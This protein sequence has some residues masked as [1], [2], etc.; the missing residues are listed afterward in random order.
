MIEF[1]IDKH[2]SLPV[3]AQLQEQIKIALMLGRLRPGDTLPSI[4]DVE[5]ET[6]ISRNI[7]RQAYLSLEKNGILTLRHGKGVMVHSSLD[8]PHKNERLDR[9]EQLVQEVLM[10]ARELDVVPSAFA[11]YLRQRAIE[12]ETIEPP[13]IY[14]DVGKQIA[15]ERSARIS[16]FW[17]MT[18][19]PFSFEE[20]VEFLSQKKPQRLCVLTNY[21]RLDAVRQMLRGKRIQV[22][23]LGLTFTEEAVRDFSGLARNSNVLLVVEDSDYPVL[24]LIAKPYR[25]LLTDESVKFE[26]RPLSKI[27]NLDALAR[28]GRYA[29]IVI[30]NRLWEQMSEKVRNLPNVTRPQLQ[31]DLPSLEEARIKAGV[32][33]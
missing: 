4:R 5:K 30:S 15:F 20:F 6:A 8:Y 12:A 17:G 9:T 25:V 24:S 1:K 22:I 28:S 23:P 19:P 10:K 29:R 21:I 7:V 11:R 31:I 32:I 14:V 27:K 26:T 3:V 16:S 13:I 33:I 2:S 18:V